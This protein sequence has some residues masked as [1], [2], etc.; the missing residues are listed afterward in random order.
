MANPHAEAMWMLM[1]TTM[2]Q[3][4]WEHGADP[5]A[6]VMYADACRAM[7]DDSE[8]YDAVIA[9]IIDPQLDR[10]HFMLLADRIRLDT[11]RQLQAVDVMLDRMSRVMYQSGWNVQAQVARHYHQ[12]VPGVFSLLG[13]TIADKD[14]RLGAYRVAA[15]AS[16]LVD[17]P[18]SKF[19]GHLDRLW[20]VMP[21]DQMRKA[22]SKAFANSLV[23]AYARPDAMRKAAHASHARSEDPQTV[24]VDDLDVRRDAGAAPW[25]R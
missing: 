15:F 1:D 7:G 9:K 14:E 17:D 5:S 23:P 3:G 6:D 12:D 24:T 2:R 10:D 20:D 11:D 13:H 19:K 16:W 18:I 21:A 8:L 4:R 25:Q 22:L